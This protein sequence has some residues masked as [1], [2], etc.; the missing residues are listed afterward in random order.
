MGGAFMHRASWVI[1]IALGVYLVAFGVLHFVLPDGL[2][3]ALGWMYDLP[4]WVHYVSGTAEILGGLGL[5]LPG[6][7]RIRPDLTPLAAAGLVALMVFAAA[8]HASRGEVQNVMSNVVL[9]AA[10]AFVAYV[11]WRRYPLTNTART[12]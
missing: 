4:T 1:Q 6:L 3:E 10:L 8:W 11:R 7:T 2:P 5:I 9:A 12:V